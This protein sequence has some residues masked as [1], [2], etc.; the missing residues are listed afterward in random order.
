MRSNRK[1]SQLRAI[2]YAYSQKNREEWKEKAKNLK[3]DKVF[4]HQKVLK[5]VRGFVLGAQTNSKGFK[6]AIEEALKKIG[7][8]DNNPEAW[9]QAHAAKRY[10]IEKRYYE[11]IWHVD[12]S[13]IEID[14]FDTV[15]EACDCVK[16]FIKTDYD[17]AK[18]I[19]NGGKGVEEFEKTIE[20]G[21]YYYTIQNRR[22]GE[23]LFT[24]F[25]SSE[26]SEV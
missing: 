5:T 13:A 22:T 15:E 7:N 25:C 17:A 26:L 1:I 8:Y 18:D 2:S 6:K 10:I 14:A 11:V 24:T 19:E 12:G 21:D 9:K 16:K 3:I 4:E 20:S 23:D